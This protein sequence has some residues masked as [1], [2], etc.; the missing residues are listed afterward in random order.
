MMSYSP[1]LAI[2][3]GIFEFAAAIIAFMSA[4]RKHILCPAGQRE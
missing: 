4:G 1:L 3:T 2:I